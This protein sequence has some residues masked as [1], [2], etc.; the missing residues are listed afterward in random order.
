MYNCLKYLGMLGGMLIACSFQARGQDSMRV[1]VL[2]ERLGPGISASAREAFHLFAGYSGFRRAV[3]YQKADSSFCV[4]IETVSPSGD[5]VSQLVGY[6]YA[7][8]RM[9]GEKVNYFEELMDGRHGMGTNPG[10]LTYVDGTDVVPSLL[11]K[12]QAE[13]EAAPGRKASL[14]VLP[15]AAQGNEGPATEY[16]HFRISAGLSSYNGD[17]GGVQT[18]LDGIVRQFGNAGYS[19]AQDKFDGPAGPMYW[20]SLNLMVTPSIGGILEIGQAWNDAVWF[21][22]VSLSACYRFPPVVGDV[23]MPYVALGIAKFSFGITR[24]YPHFERVSPM[25]SSNSYFALG[26]IQ[27]FGTGVNSGGIATVGVEIVRPS[28]NLPDLDVFVRYLMAH[29]TDVWSSTGESAALSPGGLV[30]GVR[31]MIRI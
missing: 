2:S 11:Q 30:V 5:T 9:M 27:V 4:R 15:F 12:Q 25:D 19:V 14:D 16:P 31:L 26:S 23:V 24:N 10:R 28:E 20:F 18:L 1:V 21:H 29:K 13:K 8:L 17:F 7:I 6:S 22:S 3:V